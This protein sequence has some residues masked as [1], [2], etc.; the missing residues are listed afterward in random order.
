M[1][2]KEIKIWRERHVAQTKI[3]FWT[4]L[5]HKK[6]QWAGD[7]AAGDQLTPGGIKGSG[8]TK[9]DCFEPPLDIVNTDFITSQSHA[10]MQPR[11]HC[12]EHVM[13]PVLVHVN[14]NWVPFVVHRFGF[15]R[16]NKSTN[17]VLLVSLV[18]YNFPTLNATLA[19]WL[20]SPRLSSATLH[21]PKGDHLVHGRC[22]EQTPKGSETL[23]SP[24]IRSVVPSLVSSHPNLPSSEIL[25]S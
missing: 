3:D 14:G 12:A 16:K 20:Q 4:Y 9:W 13:F 21:L 25:L 22:R 8:I 11:N 17:G 10:N 2:N 5:G 7:V 19:L 23:S 6:S 15:S 24:H 18:L 1:S